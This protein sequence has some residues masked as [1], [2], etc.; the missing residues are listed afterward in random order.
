MFRSLTLLMAALLA[1]PWAALGAQPPEE[2]L[3]RQL[4][5]WSAITWGEGC[6]VW[7]VHY[8]DEMVAPWAALEARR[9]RV[10][11]KDLKAYERSFRDSLKMDRSRPFLMTFQVFGGPLKLSPLRDHV[12]LRAGNRTFRPLDYDRRL[13]QPM[14]G[15]VQGLV[16]FPREARPPYELTVKGILPSP[17]SL[18]LPTDAPEMGAPV[19]RALKVQDVK[20][21]RAPKE[22]GGK[23]AKASQPVK[24]QSPKPEA[25]K[26]PPE[27]PQP[28]RAETKPQE[29]PE[30]P[31]VEVQRPEAPKPEAPEKPKEDP[32]RAREEAVR[33][34]LEAW[35]REDV[36]AAYGML[37]SAA[38]KRTGRR[39]FGERLMGHPFRWAL[40]E[41][42]KVSI[43][44]QGA[45]V[46]ATQR[47]LMVRMIKEERLR[48][49]EEGGR[50]LIDW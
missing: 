22:Q 20:P 32:R 44:D 5:R 18:K 4:N 49:V 42:Y 21:Q 12:A 33:A 1:L 47:F 3:A 27:R 10:R 7:L 35:R 31:K 38:K 39:E 17:V 8:P 14:S 41:G 36:D 29:A 40:K 2:A 19:V 48:L 30:T 9:G 50:Y 6:V 24:P 45:N 46:A 23:E 28:T 11:P 37:S 43:T 25:P 13:D 34:F 15:I 26:A 16:F